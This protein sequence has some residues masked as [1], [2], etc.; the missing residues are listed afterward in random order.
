MK[1][2]ILVTG[3]DGL[4]GSRFVELFPEIKLLL[5]PSEKVLD[6]TNA[7]AV[8][9]YFKKNNI[10][11]VVHFAAYTDV[12][13]AETERGDRDGLCWSVNV[14]GT[15]NLLQAVNDKN[16]QFIH[17]STDMVFSGS[18][19]DPGPYS[20]KH[21]PE[22]D[23]SKITWYGYTKLEAEKLVRKQYGKEATIVRLIYPVRANYKKKLDYLR[24]PLKL[25]KEG[26]LYP[27]FNDQQI[28]IAYIDEIAELLNKILSIGIEG[29]FHV[30]SKDTTNPYELISFLIEKLYGESYLEQVR[31]NEFLK[32]NNLSSVRYP[33]Y[34]GL[35]VEFTQARTGMNFSA[36]KEIVK[37]L[38]KQGLK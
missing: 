33:K 29:V 8:S 1:N 9:D 37:K 27:L 18:E 32:K 23:E 17:I 2:K 36:W 4:V 15:R 35:S 3:A 13:R 12:G 26:K 6:L 14:L 20:E 11:K 38:V 5:T 21:E 28:T 16:V 34:G 24:K 31:L 30:S 10:G 25:Y 19:E 22:K 7:K